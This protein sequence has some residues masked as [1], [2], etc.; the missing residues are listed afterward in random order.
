MWRFNK[1]LFGGR[2]FSSIL[3]GIVPP[4]NAYILKILVDKISE[5]NWIA[6]IKVIAIMVSINLANGL[7]HSL[8]TKKLG[9]S[10]DLFRNFLIFEL[11]SKTVNMDY[12]I[13]YDPKMIQNKEMAFKTIQE[14]RATKYIDILFSYISYFISFVSIIYLLSSFSWWVY[15]IVLLLCSIK[16]YTVI[17]DKKRTYDTSVEMAPIN[18]EITYYM[19]ML[20]DESYVN[21]MRMYSISEWVINKYRKCIDKTH[22]L[23]KKLLYGVFRNNIIRNFLSSAETAL[24]YTF[25]SFQVIFN[26]MSF[27]EFTLVTSALRTFSSLITNATGALIDMGENSAYID[28]YREY[29]NTKNIIAVPDKGMTVDLLSDSKVAYEIFNVSFSYP[30]S[31]NSVFSD[32]NLKIQKGKFYVIVGKNGAGKTTLVRLLCRLY[33]VNNGCIKYMNEDIRHIEYK[34]YRENIGVVFQD[35]KYY[36]LTIAENIAMNEYD[37]SEET[38]NRILDALYQAG[39]KDKIDS[40]PKGI[41]TQLGKIFDNEGVLL[42]G[43]ELQKLALARVLFNNPPIVILDEPSSALD[44]LAEDELIKTFNS[45]LSG[46]TVFYISH[47]L[48][49]AKYADKVIYMENGKITGFDNH[50]NLLKSSKTYRDMYE[51]QAKHYR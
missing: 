1:M 8:I 47:R 42:S 25:V 22:D 20:I 7:L 44:A 46:K 39:L 4:L 43:G 51:A 35:Y 37:E 2:L 12:E 29:M 14:G 32:L 19:N 31:S 18:T 17:V 23:V 24:V 30:G 15:L 13:L 5:L 49:V 40:L 3:N 28:I 26:D 41:D 38:R 50:E 27:A 9:V 45:A 48:S 10:N 16:I 11:N 33:D 34:S 21:D 36:C 6:S